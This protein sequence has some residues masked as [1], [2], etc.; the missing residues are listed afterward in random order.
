MFGSKIRTLLR[1]RGLESQE[2]RNPPRWGNEPE[3]KIFR[4][5]EF[6]GPSLA[7]RKELGCPVE[8]FFS[9]V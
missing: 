7:Q 8:L 4:S 9:I 1:D 2:Q 6:P 3:H 5:Q